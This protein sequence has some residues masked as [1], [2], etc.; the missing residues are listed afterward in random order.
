ME[1][2]VRCHE[3]LAR[4]CSKILGLPLRSQCQ[5]QP[6]NTTPNQR[7]SFCTFLPP[8]VDFLNAPSPPTHVRSCEAHPV[9]FSMRIVD[10]TRAS[11]SLLCAVAGCRA[12]KVGFSVPLSLFKIHG[13]NMAKITM[14]GSFVVT[15]VALT[16]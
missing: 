14:L 15:G 6:K 10:R 2:C 4:I 11:S 3:R 5:Y 1:R 9:L 8:P 7:I 12:Q 13:T 16:V